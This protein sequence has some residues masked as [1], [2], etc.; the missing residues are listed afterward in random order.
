VVVVGGGLSGLVAAWMMS[1]HDVLLLE[2]EDEAGGRICAGEWNGLTYSLGAAYTGKPDA[3][4]KGFYRE[5]GVTSVPVPPPVDGMALGGVLYP[6]DYVGAAM[7]SDAA[8]QS[9]AK[10][11]NE[12]ARLEDTGIGQAVYTPDLAALRG[13][14]KLDR[15]TLKRWLDAHGIDDIV[16]RFVDVECRGLFGV[17]HADFSLLFSIPELSY[18][19]YAPGLARERMPT[20]PVPDFHTYAPRK[21]LAE[22]DTWTFATGMMEVVDAMVA[23]PTLAGRVET[24]ARA[25]RV[26]VNRD[27]S[28]TV[29]YRQGGTNRSV[30]A[31]AAVL[32]TPAP[33][34][35]KIVESGLSDELMA[36]LRSI[37]Y[38]TYVT[39]ALFTRERLFRNAW[40]IA[41]LDTPF[42]TLNDAVRTQVPMDHDGESILG[43]AMPPADAADG[44]LL[45]MSDDALVARALKD[46]ERYLPGAGA[47][48]LGSDVKRF[49]HAFPVFGP[50]YE[51]TL[52][53]LHNDPSARGPLFLAGDYTVYPTLGGAAVSGELADRRVRAYAETVE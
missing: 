29:H 44:S 7:G 1:D 47:K 50:G 51:R 32:A 41:C 22:S 18:N 23:Q 45:G 19:F 52:Q 11:A 49:E 8:I 25:T 26:K 46:V 31:Y 14:R 43:V 9:Y 17:S 13:F 21:A 3:D 48:V 38:T 6:D 2:A 40:N 33:V 20:E 4:M 28:V 12:L 10:M 39:M 53:A 5:I 27:R 34:T 36:A 37:R 42:T 30:K 15:F 16:Q 35:A 24:G